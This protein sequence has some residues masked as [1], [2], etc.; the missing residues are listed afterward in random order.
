MSRDK[1][2]GRDEAQYTKEGVECGRIT[3]V[4]EVMNAGMAFSGEHQVDLCRIFLLMG[5]LYVLSND[6]SI[7][8]PTSVAQYAGSNASNICLGPFP[9]IILSF[10]FCAYI[11]TSPLT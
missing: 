10:K 9:C 5:Y 7:I 2:T 4:E 8:G 1:L 11:P 6:Q 3:T